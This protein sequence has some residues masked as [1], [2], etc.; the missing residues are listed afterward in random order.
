MI[1]RRI[2]S[3]LF[4]L[5]L[6]SCR[7][8]PE[9]TAALFSIRLVH[10]RNQWLIQHRISKN[11]IAVSGY[12]LMQPHPS[13]NTDMVPTAF[14]VRETALMSRKHLA[15]ARAVEKTAAMVMNEEQY[16]EFVN[17]M[18]TINSDAVLLSYDDY[19]ARTRKVATDI[20]LDFTKAG[21]DQIAR[22][23]HEHRNRRIAIMVDHQI[24]AAPVISEYINTDAL[25]L[26]SGFSKDQA[27]EVARRIMRR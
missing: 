23:T 1:G 15:R 24:I 22:I 10:P 8:Q 4:L 7:T 27:R 19:R 25:I 3:T 18:Q 12:G 5:M 6:V 2:L 17:R 13:A 11:A 20:R 21:R 14:W 16:H 9:R 26:S